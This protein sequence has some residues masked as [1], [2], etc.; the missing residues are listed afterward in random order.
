MALLGYSLLVG[1]GAVA[2]LCMVHVWVH[3]LA[4][5]LG[6]RVHTPAGRSRKLLWVTIVLVFGWFGA[7]TYWLVACPRSA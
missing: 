1:S 6:A 2:L 3:A 5:A 4:H 7:I